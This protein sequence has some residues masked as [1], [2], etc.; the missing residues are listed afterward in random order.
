MHGPR[1]S[2]GLLR[3]GL[4]LVFAL[5]LG[6]ASA[7]VSFGTDNIFPYGFFSHLDAQAFDGVFAAAV[8]E[9]AAGSVRTRVEGY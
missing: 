4:G 3:L 6:G 9:D 1:S 5:A 2:D 8:G 7:A